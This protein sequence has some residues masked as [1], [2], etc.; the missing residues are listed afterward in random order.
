M[1]QKK[2]LTICASMAFSKE[3]GIW[4]TKLAEG[5]Y[6][7]IQYPKE[8]E[9]EFLPNYKIEFSEHYQK[10]TDSDVVFIL[11]LQKKGIDG[12]IGAAVFAE[13]AFAIGLNR[14]SRQDNPI[15]VC[16]LNPFPDELPYREELQHWQ[17]LGWLVPW[18]N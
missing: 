8:F 2:K 13:I 3:I 17:D 10:M 9:G 6:E 16:H 5:G 14:T 11:N 1:T 15:K 18:E 4:R 12:Y 7:V